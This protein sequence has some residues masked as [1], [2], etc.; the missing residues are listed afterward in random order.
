MKQFNRISA[1]AAAVAM[2]AV[3]GCAE[4][5]TRSS[6]GQ[7]L[8]DTA[9]TT[10]VKTAIYSDESLRTRGISVETVNGQVQ[11]SGVVTSWNEVDHATVVAKAV[12]G[13]TSVQ[14]D[15]RVQ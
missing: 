15:L 12:G 5:P 8:D 13:V 14:N 3:V 6:T 11:L 1:L 4:T 7:Y 9:I 10:K 2:M